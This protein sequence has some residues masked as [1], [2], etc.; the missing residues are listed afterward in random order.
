MKNTLVWRYNV[1]PR[2]NLNLQA[3]LSN[4][5]FTPTLSFD[6]Q[7]SDDMSINSGSMRVSSRNRISQS[8][9]R[10]RAR[11]YKTFNEFSVANILANAKILT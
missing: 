10:G 1:W 8:L 4:N 9:D 5:Y 2:A 7:G 6:L 3:Q 11:A